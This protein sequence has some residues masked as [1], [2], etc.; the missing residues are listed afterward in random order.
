MIVTYWVAR[1]WKKLK[2]Q[3]IKLL[4]IIGYAD[5]K[6]KFAT[7]FILMCHYQ[8]MGELMKKLPKEASEQLKEELNNKGYEA[9]LQKYITQEEYNESFKKTVLENLKELLNEVSPTLN[10]TQLA[11]LNQV[12][13]RD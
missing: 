5:D 13:L 7:D 8:V 2:N 6:E 12:V 11:Q 1:K 3:L 4:T 10:E 9:N